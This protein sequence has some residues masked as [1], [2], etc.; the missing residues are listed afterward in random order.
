M[1]CI[2]TVA[3]NVLYHDKKNNVAATQGTLH[4]SVPATAL[5]SRTFS[6]TAADSV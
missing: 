5:L 4:Y 6:I 2:L 1:H 3:E